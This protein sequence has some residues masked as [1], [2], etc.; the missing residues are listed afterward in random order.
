MAK[1][2]AKVTDLALAFERLLGLRSNHA[3]THADYWCSQPKP[4]HWNGNGRTQPGSFGWKTDALACALSYSGLPDCS[5]DSRRDAIARV[6]KTC[7][8]TCASVN[9]VSNFTPI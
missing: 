1:A 6:R 9:G 8:L 5:L 2:R 3:T 7:S 4:E